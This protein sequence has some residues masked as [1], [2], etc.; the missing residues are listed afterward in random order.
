MVHI[1][2]EKSAKLDVKSRK[3]IFVG[4]SDS[5]KGYRFIEPETNKGVISRDFVFLE[6]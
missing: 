3:L 5:T 4:Y 6:A 1:S 2:K